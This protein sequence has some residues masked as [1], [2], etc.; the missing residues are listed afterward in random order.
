VALGLGLLVGLQRETTGTRYAGIRT[1]ALATVLGAVAGS[2]T[3][4]A[5][6]WVVAASLVSMAL[7]IFVGD[8]AEIRHHG[9]EVDPG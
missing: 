8:L 1:F 4:D 9:K 5:W 2:L 3:T 6:P 7:V